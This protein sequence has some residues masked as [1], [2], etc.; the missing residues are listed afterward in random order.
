MA[1]SA[2]TASPSSG[3][4]VTPLIDVLL[5]LLVIF[6]VVAPVRPFGLNSSISQGK[7]IAGVALPPVV[8][9]LLAG[10]GRQSVRVEVGHEAIAADEVVGRLRGMLAMRQDRTVFIEAERS[11]SYREV[12]AVV[13]AA[14]EA[15]AGSVVLR[16][17]QR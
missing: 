7:S 15:G 4:N 10:E 3:I 8:V 16:S 13:G 1:F 17:L 5:V 11:L 6:M 9:R 14:R 2:G 12:A